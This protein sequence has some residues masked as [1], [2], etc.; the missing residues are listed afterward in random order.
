MGQIAEKLNERAEGSL[1]SNTMKNPCEQANAITL[2]SGTILEEVEPKR[3]DKNPPKK[4]E[5]SEQEV[6]KRSLL[7]RSQQVPEKKNQRRKR[8][9]LQQMSSYAKF[10]KEIFSNKRK[11]E[12][13]ET[14]MLTEEC[15]AIL[16]KKLP[17]KLK[18][19]KSF[20]ISCVIGD[21]TFDRVF[22]DLDANINLLPFSVF[23]KLGIGEVKPIMVSLQ[24]ADR[25]IKHPQDFVVLDMEE[26]KEI[27]LILG[28]PF[29][30]TGRTLI[31]VQEGKLILRVQDEMVTFNVFEAMKFPSEVESC[32][33]VDVVDRVVKDTFEEIH[34]QLPL[35]A[36]ISK[37]K[38]TEED[39][40]RKNECAKYLEAL[41][42]M[43][44]I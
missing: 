15:N 2:R 11:L 14:M 10:L 42:P 5:E 35:E 29:L 19:L 28:R 40:P 8:Y 18:D 17:P 4:N 26:D 1:P 34:P 22:Y 30:D 25:P 39:E 37:S 31:D 16:Q 12:E 44:T 38:T 24:L 7:K 9:A 43:N 41:Q 20:I 36:C 13:K 33:G 21:V 27:R 23:E 3:K 6:M 32:F